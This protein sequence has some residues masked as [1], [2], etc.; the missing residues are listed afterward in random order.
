VKLIFC[1]VGT[2]ALVMGLLLSVSCEY[3]NAHKSDSGYYSGSLAQ[4]DS[5][6]SLDQYANR[7]HPVPTASAPQRGP[8]ANWVLTL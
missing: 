5:G 3:S 2:L 8:L 1:A 6:G 4:Y 7:S